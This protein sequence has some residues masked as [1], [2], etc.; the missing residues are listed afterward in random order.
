MLDAWDKFGMFLH[1]YSM[2]FTTQNVTTVHA[3]D[4][5]NANLKT[6]TITPFT[7]DVNSMIRSAIGGANWRMENMLFSSKNLLC[8]L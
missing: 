8:F 4:E 2:D 6:W 3:F 1:G 7:P 5:I